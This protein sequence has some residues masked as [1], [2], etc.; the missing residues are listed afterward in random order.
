MVAAAFVKVRRVVGIDASVRNTALCSISDGEPAVEFDTIHTVPEHY[1]KTVRERYRRLQHIASR[2]SV[3]LEEHP[4]ELV[5]IEDYAFAS[6]T[7]WHCQTVENGAL[8]RV[9]ALNACPDVVVVAPTS[10]KSFAARNGRAT[11]EQMIAAIEGEFGLRG[12]S[13]HEADACAAAWVGAVIQG[14]LGASCD[15]HT[16]IASAVCQTI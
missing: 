7:A 5:V 12:V 14:V 13:E 4:A 3:F 2:V 9:A 8:I 1:G 6:Q 10:L 11:K 16:E 15:R